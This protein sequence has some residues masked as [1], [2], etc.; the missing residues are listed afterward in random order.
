MFPNT[1]AML[2]TSQTIFARILSRPEAP[3]AG[4]YVQLSGGKKNMALRT[5]L[6]SISLSAAMVVAAPA[7]TKSANCACVPGKP[8]AASNTWNFKG[9]TNTLFQKIETDAQK[10]SYHADK[11]ESYTLDPELDWTVHAE[12]LSALK[13]EVNDMGKQLCRLAQIQRVVSPWQ[14]TEINHI[15]QY[16]RLM[17]NSTQDAIL[18]GTGHE[19]ELWRPTYQKYTHI[20]Y[21]EAQNLSHSVTEAVEYANTSKEYR[22]LKHDLG[23]KS[24]S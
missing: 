7:A 17:A 2:V 15:N 5:W 21:N 16:L 13:S 18:F 23:T 19:N 22:T 14:K 20:I 4:W 11:L 24:T 6:A 3:P 10:A 9:E 8:T 12:Q 1:A